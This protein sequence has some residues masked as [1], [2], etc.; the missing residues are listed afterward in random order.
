MSNRVGKLTQGGPYCDTSDLL[1]RRMTGTVS[2]VFLVMMLW[3]RWMG[4]LIDLPKMFQKA[5]PF[6]STS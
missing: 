5:M 2:F 6:Y 4:H 1:L 3:Y